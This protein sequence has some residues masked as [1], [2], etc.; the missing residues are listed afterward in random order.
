[1][2][3]WYHVQELPGP[4]P[5]QGGEAYG[6]NSAGDA[7]GTSHAVHL[8]G[9]LSVG[10][11]WTNGALVYRMPDETAHSYLLDVNAAGVAVGVQH[12]PVSPFAG[13]TE[14][15]RAIVVKGDVV[16]DLTADVG[17][18]ASSSRINDAGV[19]AGVDE[20]SGRGF[21]YDT[22]SMT[23]ARVIDPLRGSDGI[24]AITLNS[25][26]HAAGMSGDR[27]FFAGVSV[28]DLGSAESVQGLND[29]GVVSG[30]LPAPS[31]IHAEP[32]VWRPGR[33]GWTPMALPLPAGF[34]G[35]NALAIN[36]QDV[37]VGMCWPPDAH[38]LKQS[39]FVYESGTSTDLNTVINASGWRL[40][41]ATD[42]NDAGQIVGW[43][44]LH[45]ATRGFL[46][47]P[48]TAPVPP[49]APLDVPA[50]LI[51]LQHA[52][53]PVLVG[54]IFGGV[55]SDGGG[56]I[57]VGGQKIPIDPSG[58]LGTDVDL[59][60]R[61]AAM[62]LLLDSMLSSIANDV[63]R[64]RIHEALVDVVRSSVDRMAGPQGTPE[65]A[66]PAHTIAVRDLHAALRRGPTL[67]RR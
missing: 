17:P 63:A 66:D 40:I 29:A 10:T 1:M 3:S 46:L 64:A 41:Q 5:Q 4:P 53:V 47:T 8:D 50:L 59:H 37:V 58:P 36:N 26:S 35:G 25:A 27:A 43:G 30:S 16:T 12:V 14:S 61:D 45:G 28:V 54:Q 49:S 22:N 38:A 51:A 55:A 34:G 62:A 60:R 65:T 57:V 23:V 52:S 39:A 20:G 24:H 31:P 11:R 18:D 42:V 44:T 32:A 13:S 67:G 48:T 9:L 7:V 2:A 33:T 15:P 6:I 21:L 19:A 56:W